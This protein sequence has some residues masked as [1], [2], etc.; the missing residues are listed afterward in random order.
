MNIPEILTALQTQLQNST[1][2]SSVDDT[3]IFL[4]KRSNI[5]NYPVI[6]IEP[7]L[8]QKVKDEYP[9]EIWTSKINIA[10]GIKHFDESKQIVGNS[11]IDGI[12]DFENDIRKALSEDHTLGG[13]CINLSILE[14]YPDDGSDY[15]IRGFLIVIEILF[16]QNRTTR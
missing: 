1:S 7:G 11:N 15:P 9:Y 3:N 5:I 10:G 12:M 2:L 8:S 6:V 4:G 13:K 14:S 16:R